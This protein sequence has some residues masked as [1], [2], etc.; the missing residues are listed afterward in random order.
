MKHIYKRL[1]YENSDGSNRKVTDEEREA[2]IR[3]MKKIKELKIRI[4]EA[5]TALKNLS[6][7]CDHKIFYDEPGHPYDV[8][9]C[10]ICGHTSLI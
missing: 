6:A 9:H 3:K 8:R 7:N 5:Q 2:T 1:F 4:K 10:P